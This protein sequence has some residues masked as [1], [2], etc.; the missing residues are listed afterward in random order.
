MVLRWRKVLGLAS[1]RREFAR[2]KSAL[3][4]ETGN[5]QGHHGREWRR[6]ASPG[7]HGTHRVEHGLVVLLVVLLGVVLQPAFHPHGRCLTVTAP[8]R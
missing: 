7:K 5:R 6:R 2:V 3:N 4:W 8:A 1:Y